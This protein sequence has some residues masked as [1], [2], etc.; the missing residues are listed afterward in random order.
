[1]IGHANSS[2]VATVPGARFRGCDNPWHVLNDVYILH[3]WNLHHLLYNLYFGNFHNALD[4][5]NLRHLF[6]DVQLPYH[7]N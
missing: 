3:F 6:D 4:I 5:F 2:Q 7:W 1:M